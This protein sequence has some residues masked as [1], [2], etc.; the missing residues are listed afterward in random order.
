MSGRKSRSKGRRAEYLLRD[1]MRAIGFGADR[2]PLS[3]ASQGYKGDIRI[4]RG[5]CEWTLELKSRKDAFK[6]IYTFFEMHAVNSE[7]CFGYRNFLIG[8][9][10]DPYKVLQG[11]SF[12]PDPA[13]FV[14]FKRTMDKIVNMQPMLGGSDILVIKDDYEKFLFIS[15]RECKEVP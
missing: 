10:P 1:Y 2:V 4:R 7:L 5:D 3:G 6:R 12:Y 9:T 15:Y 14:A 11:F 13:P 8:I